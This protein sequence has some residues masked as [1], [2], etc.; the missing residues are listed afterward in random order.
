VVFLKIL[1]V[2]TS[3]AKKEKPIKIRSLAARIPSGG[4]KLF[5]P[6]KYILFD[7]KLVNKLCRM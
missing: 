6:T 3:D 7:E 5:S 1:R 2:A 4:R